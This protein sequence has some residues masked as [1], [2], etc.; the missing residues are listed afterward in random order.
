MMVA[1]FDWRLEARGRSGADVSKVTSVCI[2]Q[3][4]F[5]HYIRCVIHSNIAAVTWQSP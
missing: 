4:A 3:Q 5:M 2:H 1:S